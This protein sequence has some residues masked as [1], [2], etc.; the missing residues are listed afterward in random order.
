MKNKLLHVIAQQPGKTGSGIYV[1]NL[2]HQAHLKGYEQALVAGIPAE[3]E[4]GAYGLPESVRF[5]PVLFETQ[6]L[7][8]PVVGMSDEMPYRSTPYGA[9]D[10]EALRRWERAFEEALR[11]AVETFKPDIILSHHLWLLTALVRRWFPEIPVVAF[12][13]GSDLRQMAMDADKGGRVRSACRSLDRIMALNSFQKEL[14][15][16]GC[17]IEPER[18]S[19]VGAGYDSR[20]FHEAGDGSKAA[21]S[22]VYAGKISEAKGVG[23]LLDAFEHL[24][25]KRPEARLFL[26]GSGSGAGYE[27]LSARARAMKGV[28]LLGPLPQPELAGLF[29]RSDVFALPSFYEGLPLVLVEAAACG[30]K[31]AVSGLGGLGDWLGEKMLESGGAEL[32]ALPAMLSVDRPDPR[33]VGEFARRFART[34]MGQLDR[35]ETPEADAARREFVQGKSWE[36]IFEKVERCLE[37]GCAIDAFNERT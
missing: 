33:H 16:R 25:A 24:R 10:P 8:F 23:I 12:S 31:L 5:E 30:M 13:H 17:G 3:T 21:G 6:A 28:S 37:D 9:L 22:I 34:L 27:L 35:P 36:S 2:V 4:T 32:V 20:C 7:P 1:K 11:T 18:I 15:G 29:R 19:V 14:I 26:A